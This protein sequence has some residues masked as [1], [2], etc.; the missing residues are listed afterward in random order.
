[1]P[2]ERAAATAQTTFD[3][4]RMSYNRDVQRLRIRYPLATVKEHDSHG[5][6]TVFTIGECRAVINLEIGYGE[7][8]YGA[9][10]ASSR[11]QTGITWT[12]SWAVFLALIRQLAIMDNTTEETN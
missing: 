10:T 6:C 4:H 9:W 7:K 5:I 1:L 12:D 3:H 11:E 8:R 2:P